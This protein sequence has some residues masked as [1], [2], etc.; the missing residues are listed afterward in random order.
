MY[1]VYVSYRDNNGNPNGDARWGL[2]ADDLDAAIAEAQSAL[3]AE[4]DECE[5]EGEI[6]YDICDEDNETVGTLSQEYSSTKREQEECTVLTEDEGEYCT[7]Y[8]GYRDQRW[9]SEPQFVRWTNN[10]G[11]GGAFS[12]QCGDGQWRE[13]YDSPEEIS[14]GQAVVALINEFGFSIRA[15]AKAIA[16]AGHSDR[17]EIVDA[18]IDEVR[19]IDS[20]LDAARA[21]PGVRF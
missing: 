7:M 1:D 18:L 16:D 5:G 12:R 10:G 21:M 20:K 14:A 3:D 9:S 6:T 4:C 19:G 17:D 15:A 8:I 11:Y 13:S 2:E